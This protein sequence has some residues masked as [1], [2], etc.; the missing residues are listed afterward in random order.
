MSVAVPHGGAVIRWAKGMRR[1]TKGGSSIIYGVA[2]PAV[3]QPAFREKKKKISNVSW[4]H[5]Q[6]STCTHS[7]VFNGS[8]PL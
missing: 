2:L 7:F 3:L 5:F 4:I 6:V 8:I 1:D